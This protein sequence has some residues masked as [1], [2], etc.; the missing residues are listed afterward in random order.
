MT[1]LVTG[2][3]TRMATMENKPG[4]SVLEW[5]KVFELWGDGSRSG[6][7]PASPSIAEELSERAEPLDVVAD[8]LDTRRK[9]NRQ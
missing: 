8:R 6:G 3:D 1:A 9:G 4:T 5:R 2:M 7:Q